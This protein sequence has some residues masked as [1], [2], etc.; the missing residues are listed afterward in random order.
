MVQYSN[1]VKFLPCCCF[2]VL[3]ELFFPNLKY[4][5]M[6]VQLKDDVVIERKKK[7]TKII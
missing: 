5:K 1:P 6:G 3:S 7:W 4:T 2:V